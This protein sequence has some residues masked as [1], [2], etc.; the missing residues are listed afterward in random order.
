MKTVLIVD[1]EAKIRDVVASYL[2]RE[3]Y[4]TVEASNGGE[5]LEAFANSA[6]DLV[7]LDLMLPDMSGEDVCRTLRKRSPVPVLML[8]A[9]VAEQERIEGLS[10]GADDYVLKPFSPRELVARVRAVLRRVGEHDLLAERIEFSG[11]LVIDS[12]KKEVS[13]PGGIVNRTIGTP[14]KA[15]CGRGRRPGAFTR[16]SG[17]RGP[18][19]CRASAGP[20]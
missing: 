6:V 9:K 4:V 11:G 20:R 2:Q 8:T 17:S 3:G 12:M 10:L 1:D 19:R 16:M 14:I 18:V 7:I 5:A 15:L 13:L